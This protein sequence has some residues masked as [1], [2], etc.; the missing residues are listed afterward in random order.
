MGKS[1]DIITFILKTRR[2]AIFADIIKIVIMFMKA[3]KWKEIGIMYQNAIYI[4]I[5][6]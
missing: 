4:C 3:I 5:S 2:V 1:Y 6:F